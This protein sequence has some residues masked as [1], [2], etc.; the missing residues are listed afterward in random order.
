MRTRQ[1]VPFTAFSSTEGQGINAPTRLR[2]EHLEE[3]LGID[4]ERPRL[5]WWLPLGARE[6]RAYR[7]RTNVSDS[8]RVESNQSL[9][10]DFAGPPLVS[11]QRVEC[12][13]KVWTD[14]GESEWSS[15]IGWEMGLLKPSEWVA[16]W[17]EP[18][19]GHRALQ[20]LRQ[21]YGTKAS[22]ARRA[23][24]RARTARRW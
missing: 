23:S 12:A 20:R 13:V 11:R 1:S 4:V 14:K 10:V 21:A 6:Q 7:V 24:G 2:V 5:S 8:G 16:R 19:G 17:I 9:L 15:P 3:P 22:A 18:R